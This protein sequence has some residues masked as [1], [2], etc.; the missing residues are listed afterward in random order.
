MERN[1]P[2]SRFG[3]FGGGLG[4]LVMLVCEGDRSDGCGGG[5]PVTEWKSPRASSVR[6]ESLRV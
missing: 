5:G 4:V 2:R 6:R 3:G 1:R